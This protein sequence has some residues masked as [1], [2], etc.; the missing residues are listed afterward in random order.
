MELKHFGRVHFLFISFLLIG[1]S[2]FIESTEIDSRRKEDDVRE[3]SNKH[4][5]SFRR[6]GSFFAAVISPPSFYFSLSFLLIVLLVDPGPSSMNKKV[7]FFS[8]GGRREGSTAD[9]T[10][11]VS[12][13]W[14]VERLDRISPRSNSV[15]N[16]L[17]VYACV[18]NLSRV[19]RSVQKNLA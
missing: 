19:D 4:S 2:V 7:R 10:A 18:I 5:A 12:F 6:D 13:L 11:H 3:N 16:D 14:F 8:V 17:W 1:P 15:K 9:K